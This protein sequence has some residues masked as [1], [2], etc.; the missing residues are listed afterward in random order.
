MADISLTNLIQIKIMINQL[1]N[2]IFIIA[3]FGVVLLFTVDA[4]MQSSKKRAVAPL[5]D[6]VFQKQLFCTLR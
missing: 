4:C 5:K 3:Y 2:Q 1:I 6:Y